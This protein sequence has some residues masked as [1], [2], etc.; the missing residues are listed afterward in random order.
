M[1]EENVELAARFYEPATSKAELLSAMPRTLG[2]CHPE[3]E[4]T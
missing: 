3:V 2:F 4:S 1:S